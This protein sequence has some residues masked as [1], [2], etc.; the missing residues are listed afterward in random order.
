MYRITAFVL[1]VVYIL[2]FLGMYSLL[3]ADKLPVFDYSFF[4]MVAIFW[5]VYFLAK[6]N[7]FDP[8]VAAMERRRTFISAREEVHAQAGHRLQEARRTFD[9]NLKRVREEERWALDALRKEL[10]SERERAMAA[11]K[12]ELQ[13][14][15]DVRREA[16]KAEAER[17]RA[18]LEPEVRR[19]TR[20]VVSKVLERDVA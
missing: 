15:L 5:A 6:R 9:L 14:D 3:K 17:L 19:M 18:V 10:S 11:L 1:P 8:L 16:L 13:R 20:A 12:A 7:L 4:I 2:L